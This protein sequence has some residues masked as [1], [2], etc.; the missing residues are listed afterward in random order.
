[1][2]FQILISENLK[3]SK[4]VLTKVK[5]L[6]GIKVEFFKEFH[7][8]SKLHTQS[9]FV[10]MDEEDF[11]SLLKKDEINE[12]EGY[13]HLFI[14]FYQTASKIA[15]ILVKH[16][17]NC[18]FYDY[19]LLD[20]LPEIIET[21]KQYAEKLRKN[22]E[23]DRF[24]LMVQNM[25][26]LVNALDENAQYVFWNKECERV[27]GY[28]AEEIINNPKA[29]ELLFPDPEYRNQIKMEYEK[30]G[31]NFRNWELKLTTKNGQ[32]K[33]I[34]WSNLSDIYQVPGWANWAVGVDVNGQSQIKAKLKN[35]E[36]VF[37][38]IME[39]AN[40]INQWQ[41]EE[42]II[43]RVMHKIREFLPFNSNIILFYDYQQQTAEILGSI[44]E[45]Q[46]YFKAGKPIS[47]KALIN[48]DLVIK[49]KVVYVEDIS[50]YKD[51]IH[52]VRSILRHGHK[53]GFIV[54]L[55][56]EDKIVGSM[57]FFFKEPY[58]LDKTRETAL[59]YVGQKLASALKQ[60][61]LVQEL[62]ER[63]IALE[64]DRLEYFNDLK[65]SEFRLRAQFEN[66]PIP[67]LIWRKQRDD[68]VL[69]DY[70][71][72]ALAA[73]YGKIS[74]FMGKSSKETPLYSPKLTELL[75]ECFI[76][77]ITLETQIKI[78]WDE[79][80]VSFYALKMAYVAPDTVVMHIEDI[81][82]HKQNELTISKLN[83]IIHNQ[84]KTIELLKEERTIFKENLF[85]VVTNNCKT[86]WQ[87]KDL[88]KN[89]KFESLLRQSHETVLGYL[90]FFTDYYSIEV[91]RIFKQEINLEQ[92]IGKII[93]KNKTLLDSA[94]VKI[95]T[96]FEE[97]EIISDETLLGNI[98]E[99]II[100]LSIAQKHPERKH[101]I[102]FISSKEDGHLKIIANDNGIG[103][104]EVE[105]AKFR[106]GNE[107][108]LD[109]NN[110]NIQ[111]FLI[112]KKLASII[113][114]SVEFK[115]VPDEGCQISI[116]F[117]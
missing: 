16:S 23:Q 41:T 10:V 102:R 73:T 32:Q 57:S 20:R 49:G 75:E 48:L 3:Q 97:N 83:Q 95:L 65:H 17:S 106:E 5:K 67:T 21:K 68:F 90:K 45:N 24:K 11:I 111:K 27:T 7:L 22:V 93:A 36:F 2:Q 55:M 81:T 113:G 74:E 85:P 91:D 84:L 79:E 70:N 100:Q 114:S 58:V 26:V 12:Y 38:I 44:I 64:N 92:L 35:T 76:N 66:L 14:V 116:V 60:R 110:Q 9:V 39:I 25:P 31:N 62:N 46:F 77:E 56:F 88:V 13:S 63:I 115:S 94:D 80:K 34:A 42:Q 59:L 19:N 15:D 108:D 101:V 29:I 6:E 4:Q 30:K 40:I 78:T 104:K 61:R 72:M 99:I 96:F 87:N 51:K 71:D 86:L 28:S 43:E 98:V 47:L 109:L 117:D 52:L 107:F 103:M 54:P 50:V 112:L 18:E 33:V 53:S 8:N 37:N 89:R 82:E 1:M 105:K 69:V